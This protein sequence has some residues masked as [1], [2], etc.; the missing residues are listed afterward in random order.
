MANYN[1]FKQIVNTNLPT[2]A[3]GL[4]TAAKLRDT[5][6]SL[7]DILKGGWLFAGMAQPQA[8]ASATLALPDAPVFY[9]AN[10][11]GVYAQFRAEEP[12]V[13]TNT[14]GLFYSQQGIWRMK[15]LTGLPI[16]TPVT[17][18]E[19]V[20]S[21]R[22]I[23][24]TDNQI[25]AFLTTFIR[26]MVDADS[27]IKAELRSLLLTETITSDDSTHAVVAS[28]IKAYIDRVDEALRADLDDC[29]IKVGLSNDLA[30]SSTWEAFLND[31]GYLPIPNKVVRVNQTINVPDGC[32]I[33][34][35][36][37]KSIIRQG[38][39]S[40]GPIFNL[41]GSVVIKDLTFKG[42]EASTY[43]L[44]DHGFFANASS[45]YY[46]REDVTSIRRSGTSPASWQNASVVSIIDHNLPTITDRAIFANLTRFPGNI[47]IDNVN[48]ENFISEAVRIEGGIS[49]NYNC[50]FSNLN[51]TGCGVGLW[52]GQKF[53]NAKG[54]NLHFSACGIGLM[55][56]G[57]NTSFSNLHLHGCWCGIA[58][59]VGALHKGPTYSNIEIHTP[60]YGII[61][62]YSPSD[63]SV[64]YTNVFIE[65]AK[66]LSIRGQDAYN[67]IITNITTT[68]L[69]D[70]SGKLF[71]WSRGSN[72]GMCFAVNWYSSFTPSTLPFGLRVMDITAEINRLGQ[73]P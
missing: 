34:G 33:Y 7:A 3:V 16:G 66:E 47:T 41:K 19:L 21:V 56:Q 20:A 38:N 35:T 60:I 58:D 23:V 43:T 37:P 44:D 24:T 5:L 4:I 52:L 22:T 27:Q 57:G 51:F 53:V 36:G 62:G 71:K 54:S 69:E 2:N 30:D 42:A 29:Q 50:T 48:F 9:L 61:N 11:A 1:E 17:T 46:I 59:Y 6:T 15:L 14:W 18:D 25:E 73:T 72:C 67:V 13:L 12:Y 10:T 49:L 31:N 45:S 8:T 68:D 63:G 32:V 65:A 39:S 64:M 26:A 70:N 28:A 40:F 55:N